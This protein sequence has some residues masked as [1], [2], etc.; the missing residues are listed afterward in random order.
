MENPEQPSSLLSDVT[1]VF[2]SR[3]PWAKRLEFVLEM[4]R[5][6]S[7]HTD[8]M[9]MVKSYA[10]HIRRVVPYDSYLSLSRRG[11]EHPHFRITRSETLGKDFDPWQN[12]HRIPL[13]EGGLLAELI[14]GEE[15]AVIDDLQLEPSDPAVPFL[16][17]VRSL[18]AIP[19]YDN[20]K[21]LNMSVIARRERAA[22]DRTMLPAL[23]ALSNLFGRAAHAQVLRRELG[24]AY[25]SLDRELRVVADIQRG[26]LPSQL[27]S[28]P[29][30]EMSAFYHA[31][32]RAGGDYY[33]VFPL[34]ATA[35]RHG[36]SWG[37]L[38]ADVS[39]HG[40]PAAVMMA[41]THSIAHLG[42]DLPGEPASM[43]RFINENLAARY[44]AGN[45]RFV[46]GI[47]G[48]WDPNSRTLRYANAGHPPPLRRKVDGQVD[49]LDG[50]RGLP[51]GVEAV[52]K[53]PETEQTLAPGETLLMFTDGITES[54]R[55]TEADLFGEKRLASALAACDGSPKKVIEQVLHELKSFT[56]G[57][58][59]ADD[60][61][62]L[63]MKVR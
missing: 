37:I 36:C 57:A 33:D 20:G 32:A 26:L 44:T 46:T 22:F 9:D 58:P 52:E 28:I 8:P 41:I 16:K 54:R 53:F 11:L 61:T 14:Y 2:D 63:V 43:L 12:P 51:L 21:S 17:G 5:D 1:N 40:P 45:G 6:L 47:Y 48:V 34:A 4:M 60:R 59:A 7:N 55:G 19:L 42:K 24:T 35:G 15:P 10:R 30:L 31:S 23:V 50:E 3:T 49:S 38:L 25:E 62:L 39:G 56:D 18:V 29:N 13:F 27:P